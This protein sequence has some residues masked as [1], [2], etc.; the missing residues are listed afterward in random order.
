MSTSEYD[1]Y[2]YMNRSKHGVTCGC[3][4]CILIHNPE[5]ITPNTTYRETR[6]QWLQVDEMNL[7][8]G[9]DVSLQKVEAS[10]CEDED[11]MVS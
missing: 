5:R 4:S 1:D 9:V 7:P 10:H 6:P 2:C 3:I 8:L 11:V